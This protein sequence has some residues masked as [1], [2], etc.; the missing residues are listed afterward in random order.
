[1]IYFL[2]DEQRY[3]LKIY[4]TNYSKKIY[5]NLLKI[6][7]L[8]TLYMDFGEKVRF[9]RRVKGLTQSELADKANISPAY[10]NQIE[11]GKEVDSIGD[12]IIKSIAIALEATPEELKNFESPQFSADNE[13]H[14]S[15]I[16]STT[17]MEAAFEAERKGWQS[18]EKSLRDTISVQQMAIDVLKDLLKTYQSMRNDK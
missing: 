3:A 1:M 4:L 18:L 11:K 10:M 14:K 15:K 8:I 5:Y 13:E 16:D 17:A 12:K 2:R 9:L 7:V 6:L